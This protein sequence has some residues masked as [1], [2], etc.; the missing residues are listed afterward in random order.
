MILE[1]WVWVCAP[2]GTTCCDLFSV[3]IF[4]VPDLKS[5][6]SSMTYISLRQNQLKAVNLDYFSDFP[7][8]RTLIF[9]SNQITFINLTKPITPLYLYFD[10]NELT[11]IDMNIFSVI[12]EITFLT[13]KSNPLT[14]IIY[15]SSNG[16]VML[17]KLSLSYTQMINKHKKIQNLNSLTHLELEYTGISTLNYSMFVDLKELLDLDLNRNY[18]LE[19][20]PVASGTSLDKLSQLKLRMCNMH[21]PF[22][23]SQ[24]SSSIL[25]SLTNLDLYYNQLDSLLIEEGYKL[26][27][28]VYLQLERN[29]IT[30]FDLYFFIAVF[31]Q[32][33]TLT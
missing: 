24:V 26:S 21:G 29:L 13:F 9:S 2:A 23:F 6:N 18:N 17:S 3:F 7:W 11:S 19:I 14:E 20:A 8:M 1:A 16:T 15:P 27:S 30:E 32:L 25:P 12:T 4:Q 28:L 22:N 33:V 10:S 5:F 31:P